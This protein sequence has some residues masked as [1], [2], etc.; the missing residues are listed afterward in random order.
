M[1][2][3]SEG[4]TLTKINMTKMII[5]KEWLKT[6]WL[7][8]GIAVVL[9]GFSFYCFLNL[10]KVV[11]FRGGGIL[12]G[13]LVAKDTVLLEIL[14]YLPPVASAVLALAQ[15][16]PEIQQKRLKLTLHLPYPQGR[17]ILLIA[18]YGLVCLTTLFALQ[19]TVSALVLK[20]WI[21]AELVTRITVTTLVWY[22]AGWAAYLFTA[23]ICLEPAWGMR[24]VIL[25][26][27][28]GLLRIMYLSPVPEAY[29]GFLPWLI[30]YVL[31]SAVLLFHGTA[32][33]KEGLHA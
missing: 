15:F 7:L 12:W 22:L 16:L 33:F 20:K 9:A 6:R 26:L 13:T 27:M 1:V 23:S 11:E 31:C 4:I 21:V 19:A 8:L 28:A 24:V 17:M 18:A 5:Y 3:K 30:I 2:T 10:S 32:R 25:L 29:N 14:R